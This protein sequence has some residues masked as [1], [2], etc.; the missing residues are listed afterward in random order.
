METAK[1]LNQQAPSPIYYY[2]STH[3][4]ITMLCCDKMHKHTQQHTEITTVEINL[5]FEHAA[6]NMRPSDM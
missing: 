5:I 2:K 6:L 1:Q 3:K 4:K